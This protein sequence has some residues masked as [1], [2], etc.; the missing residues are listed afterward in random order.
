MIAFCRH[1]Y[2]ASTSP[3]AG[4]TEVYEFGNHHIYTR[5]Y[6]SGDGNPTFTLS[7]VS[8][9]ASGVIIS[10]YNF[11]TSTLF[12]VS[13]NESSFSAPASPYDVTLSSFNTVT[14]GALALFIWVSSD[15]NTWVYQS[16]GAIGLVSYNVTIA[17]DFS[18]CIAAKSMPT[19]GATG[20]QVARQ[21]NKA[22]DAGQVL[23]FAIKPVE[24]AAGPTNLKTINNLA[25]ASVKTINGLAIASVKTW[26][27]LAQ[28]E[29]EIIWRKAA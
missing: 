14:D 17:T 29:M 18:Y 4:W 20:N 28:E 12:D 24:S 19:Y 8:E 22:G 3:P 13:I 27:T 16:G 23:R 25:K 1:L 11:N 5:T 7:G 21:T 26:D 2:G 9:S 10:I 15:D 6:Q